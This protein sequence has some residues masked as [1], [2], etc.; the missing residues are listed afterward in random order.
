MSPSRLGGAVKLSEWQAEV[1]EPFKKRH[2]LRRELFATR[3]A[4]IPIKDLY[5][6]E[7]LGGGWVYE[8]KLGYPGSYPFT[9]GVYPTGYR[10][11]VWTIRQ[12]AGYG[13]PRETNTIFRQ[14]LSWGQTGLS[15]ALDLPTQV[16]YDPDHPL[17]HGEVGKVGVS[18]PSLKEM[19]LVFDGIPLDRVSVSF[20]IN[21]TASIILAMYIALAERRGIPMAALAGTVQNDNLKELT[22]RNAFIFPPRPS[23]KLS[24]DVIEFCV[25]RMPRFHP[26]NVC[27]AHYRE[28]G[29]NAATATGLAFAN[30]IAYITSTLARGLHIDEFAG[31]M[32][33]YTYS[34]MDLFE[35]VAKFRAM[36]RLWA[37]M[38]RERFGARDP[39]SMALKIGT[40]VGGSVYTVEEPYI[41]I[42]RG[43]IG[44]LAAVLGGVQSMNIACFD[45][46]YAIP[47]PEALKLSVRTQE[48]IAYES[49]AADVV[50]PL[51]GSYYVEWLTD[52][53]ERRIEE[54]IGLVEDAGGAVA[55]IEGGLYHQLVTREAYEFQRR[56]ESGELP[57]VAHNL[58]R[59]GGSQ[60]LGVQPY[61]PRPELEVE[62]R[63]RLRRLRGERDGGRVR[64]TLEAVRQAAVAGENLM[65][66]I[67]E[68]VKAYATVGEICDVLRDVYGEYREPLL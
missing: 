65:P 55:A 67:L 1:L 44:A 30:A 53:M 11:R 64:A 60:G 52:E 17:A 6:P 46:A 33:F 2:G 63:E 57:I 58:F 43:T 13:D 40:A 29:A 24:V 8:E 62:A 59:D 12:Y 20:T 9:R 38:M 4:R 18:V 45:E 48:I 61:T 34:H 47:T 66:A 3:T 50:D 42:V 39:A 22:A 36:R 32:A 16:G 68:A 37:R 23:L 28:A 5:T 41:N 19:E 31:K 54:V 51:G 56:V 21:A 35:E 14:L 7:D 26:I 10:G 15:L 49:G 25:R 27:E